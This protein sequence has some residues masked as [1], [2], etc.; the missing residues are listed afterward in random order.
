M[1]SVNCNRTQITRMTQIL[2]DKKY[3]NNLMAFFLRIEI[4]KKEN[5][6]R[7]SY[8]SSRNNRICKGSIYIDKLWIINT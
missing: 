2:T 3:L 6:R 7:V 5:I 1:S 4:F 8:A